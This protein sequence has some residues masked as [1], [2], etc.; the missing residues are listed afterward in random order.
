VRRAQ[1]AG[2]QVHGRGRRDRSGANPVGLTVGRLCVNTRPGGCLSGAPLA[3]GRTASGTDGRSIRRF[4]LPP[5]GRL[6]HRKCDQTPR[7]QDGTG[8]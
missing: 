4:G 1:A 7:R 8:R 5:V 2:E 6:D 3:F